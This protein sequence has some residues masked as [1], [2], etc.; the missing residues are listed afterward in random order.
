MLRGC[1][2]LSRKEVKAVLAALKGKTV[3]DL[4]DRALFILGIKTGLRISELLS[5]RLR[6]VSR[7]GQILDRVAVR[8]GAT[9]GKRSG[10]V[11]PLNRDASR[12]LLD[13]VR[14]L[15]RMGVGE[16]APLFGSRK[17][18][19]RRPLSRFQAWRRLKDLYE[20]AGLLLQNLGTHTLRKTFANEIYR[21]LGGDLLKVQ[22]ALGH[23]SIESTRCYL[24]FAMEE[25]E[26]AILKL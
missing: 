22:A 20:R 25:V 16:N 26:E 9:K 8:R 4:R 15:E 19:W 14:R 10:R 7:R 13:L 23:A 1:R 5:L 18:R 3:L 24:A 2:P 11:I 21:L 6:D 12:A 17:G